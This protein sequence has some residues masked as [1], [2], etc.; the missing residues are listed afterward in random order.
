MKIFLF[1]A[2]S[3][4]FPSIF[5]SVFQSFQCPSSGTNKTIRIEPRFVT[6]KKEAQK[7]HVLIATP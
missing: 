5:P 2:F 3:V 6:I 7:N 1:V 4:R